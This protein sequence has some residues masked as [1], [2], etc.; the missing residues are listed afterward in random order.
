M[1]WPAGEHQ[2]RIM[3]GLAY[4]AGVFVCF[5]ILGAVLLALK[6][7]GAAVGWGFLPLPPRS[8]P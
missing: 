3:G 5:L 8:G 2:E 1:A 7:G 4:T 6:A